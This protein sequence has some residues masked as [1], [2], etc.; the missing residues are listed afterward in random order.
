MMAAVAGA[1]E[2]AGSRS[3]RSGGWREAFLSR[4]RRPGGVCDSGDD[5]LSCDSPAR[6]E[7]RE[8]RARSLSRPRVRPIG[9][10]QAGSS[11]ADGFDQQAVLEQDRALIEQLLQRQQPRER[12]VVR[13]PP[14]PPKVTP[15]RPRSGSITP[16][17]RTVDAC[18]PALAAASPSPIGG[19]SVEVLSVSADA[20]DTNLPTSPLGDDGA[21]EEG[22]PTG[23][24]GKHLLGTPS[25]PG[26]L[27]VGCARSAPC[28]AG[29][30]I[31]ATPKPCKS[32]CGSVSVTQGPQLVAPVVAAASPL[33]GEPI[34]PKCGQLFTANDIDTIM[35]RLDGGGNSA[36]TRGTG[37]GSCDGLRNV[38]Q[39]QPRRAG[40]AVEARG[41]PVLRGE[42]PSHC[43][44]S[45]VDISNDFFKSHGLEM[46]TH[47]VAPPAVAAV[48][49]MDDHL[50]VQR[51]AT[52]DCRHHGAGTAPLGVMHLG[53]PSTS[54]GNATA[55]DSTNGRRLAATDPVD[56]NFVVPSRTELKSQIQAIDS[57]LEEDF[58]AREHMCR[59]MKASTTGAPPLANSFMPD[60]GAATLKEAELD[61]SAPGKGDE[62][63]VIRKLED[64]KRRKA[65]G[66]S[67]SLVTLKQI[68]AQ[69]KPILPSLSLDKLVHILR[70]FTSA[71]YEDHDLYLRILGEIPVQIRGIS[72]EML[73]TCVRVLWRL[74]LHE[75]TYLELFSMEAMNMIRAKQRSGN[76]AP[77]RRAPAPRN[78]T[79]DAA[80]TAAISSGTAPVPQPPPPRGEAT[81]PFSAL[82][83]VHVGNALS[84][85]GAK[86]PARFMDVY[87]EQLAKAIQRLTRE[88]CEM[89][90]PTLAMSQLVHDP[91]RRAFLERCAEV[92]A[93]CD[94]PFGPRLP[95]GGPAPEIAQ[96]QREA[97][98]LRRRQKNARN[99]FIIEASVRKETFSFFSSL[100]AEVRAYLD[101]IH[102]HAEKLP[103]EG[104][105]ALTHQV[106]LVL[107]QLGVS[108]ELERMA[109]PL[110]LHIVAKATN[111]HAEEEEVVY[112]CSDASAYYMVQDRSAAP[113][114]TAFARLRHRLLQR[115]GKRLTH[116]SIWEWQ[117]MSDAQR[118]NYMVKLQ[119]LQ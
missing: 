52:A 35:D 55:I 53:G 47:V 113:E 98:L 48:A 7:P 24:T 102:S 33:T 38:V 70:L 87:Q 64:V 74:Q 89:V 88:E 69:A 58:S 62:V 2:E 117:Q 40:G 44:H 82:Q 31:A 86:H 13:K 73:T 17:D 77:P 104:P 103:H 79:V 80:A 61:G 59:P 99:V 105:T 83:L 20:M 66:E 51:E 78:M 27:G 18:A 67:F 30:V 114:L 108:C 8:R 106:A 115:L 92:E 32:S 116:I 14:P 45:S 84:Q 39:D 94:L 49:H 119:S 10:E 93:G 56:A 50:G 81:A 19:S 36:V 28:A 110:G 91:L 4:H 11:A 109:G 37:I 96:Y 46:P 22:S 60:P 101:K 3:A 65:A 95:V 107:D 54:G 29:V 85:L 5:D 112:E 26:T 63:E 76:R 72:P 6:G 111:P 118:V 42:A 25:A 9:S 68:A 16:A 43:T 90:S 15:Y 34:V 97:E 12:S 1:A 23:M 57:W 71:R 41:V 21:H 100:P 75:A